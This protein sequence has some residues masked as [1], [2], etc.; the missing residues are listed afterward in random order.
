MAPVRRWAG[1]CQAATAE[2]IRGPAAATGCGRGASGRGLTLWYAAWLHMGAGWASRGL[3][4]CAEA[5]AEPRL[6]LRN[7]CSPTLARGSGG[8][9]ATRAQGRTAAGTLWRASRGSCVWLASATGPTKQAATAAAPSP[10][11]AIITLQCIWAA[12]VKQPRRPMLDIWTTWA[13]D[14]ADTFRARPVPASRAGRRP[15]CDCCRPAPATQRAGRCAQGA[16]ERCST[17]C[18]WLVLR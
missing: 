1:R 9:S 12:P 3:C 8:S 4:R 10:P 18:V 16:N 14:A 17:R 6:M 7:N 5:A 2:A 11:A 13:A 15:C